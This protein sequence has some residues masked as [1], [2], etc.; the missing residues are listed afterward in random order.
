MDLQTFSAIVS[1]V[2]LL[3]P[4]VLV[5]IFDIRPK[6]KLNYTQAIKEKT[7]IIPEDDVDFF[8]VDS[9]PYKE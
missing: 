1:V 3:G 5:F 6:P 7:N 9:D 4:P 8:L 2:V